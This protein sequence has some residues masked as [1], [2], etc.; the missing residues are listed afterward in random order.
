MGKI[1]AYDRLDLSYVASVLSYN[2]KTGV[3]TWNSKKIANGKV[4]GSISELGY[5]YIRVNGVLIGAHVLAWAISYGSWPAEEIDHKN[6]TPGDDRLENLRIATRCENCRNTKIRS[7]NSSGFKGVSWDKANGK[8]VARVREP[9]GAYKNLGRFKN[10]TEAALAYNIAATKY[11][12]E[13]A[14]VNA[15]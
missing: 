4:A 14:K 9:D 2:E 13:F 15:L 6:G 8:W 12:G 7:N 1:R 11:Y 3:F 5:R 10:P